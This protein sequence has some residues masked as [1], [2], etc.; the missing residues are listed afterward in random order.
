MDY[1]LI[2]DKYCDSLGIN[3]KDSKDYKQAKYDISDTLSEIYAVTEFPKKTQY[4]NMRETEDIVEDFADTTL[5]D[6]L[7]SSGFTISGGKASTISSG[8]V[9][10]TNLKKITDIVLS[11]S[12][13][14]ISPPLTIFPLLRFTVTN[15]L[16]EVLYDETVDFTDDSG[17]EEEITQ[18]IN[19][20]GVNLT[21]TILL[22]KNGQTSEASIHEISLIQDVTS[23]ILPS[24]FLIPLEVIFTQGEENKIVASSEISFERFQRWNPNKLFPSEDEVS[25]VTDLKPI[26]ATSENEEFDRTVGYTFNAESDGVKLYIKPTFNGVITLVYT[27]FPVYTDLTEGN[28]L[29]MHEVF[30]ECVVDGAVYRRLKKNLIK[31]ISEAESDAKV[32]AITISM[33]E[34]KSAYQEGLKRFRAFTQKTADSV[35][36]KPFSFLNDPDMFAN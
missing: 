28:S 35:F 4:F 15:E 24:D 36:V 2:V 23:V 29:Q 18:S 33:R 22:N 10:I 8:N 11:V 30:A 34:F 26:Y 16:S 14:P 12:S 19:V 25:S 7:T 3:N 27:H 21:L 6:N 20:T 5:I 17:L 32:T 13:T 31:A 1:K 9:T